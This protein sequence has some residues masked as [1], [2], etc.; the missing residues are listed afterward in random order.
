[1]LFCVKVTWSLVGSAPEA[2]AQWA[3][4]RCKLLFRYSERPLKDGN[5]PAKFLPRFLKWHY[6]NPAVAEDL[7]ALRQCFYG[8]R[9]REIRAFSRAML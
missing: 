6:Y 1:M 4:R 9:L 5:P 3:A 7:Y 8:G 2:L